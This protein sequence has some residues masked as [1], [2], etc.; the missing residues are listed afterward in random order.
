MIFHK[1]RELRVLVR[2]DDYA[3]VGDLDGFRW[4][5][6]QLEAKFEMKTVVVG[7]SGLEGVVT[8]GKILNWIIRTT[9][10]VAV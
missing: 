4:L 8:E 6:E 9:D 7:L 3:R 10:G 5:Q 2:G 1:H